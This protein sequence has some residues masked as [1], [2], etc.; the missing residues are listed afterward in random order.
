MKKNVHLA[1]NSETQ[2]SLHYQA[3]WSVSICQPKISV[4][5]IFTMITDSE[6]LYHRSCQS[7]HQIYLLQHLYFLGW[8]M[9]NG[10]LHVIAVRAWPGCKNKQYDHGVPVYLS[11]KLCTIIFTTA[12]IWNVHHSASQQWDT[13]QS[14]AACRPVSVPLL[15]NP[16]H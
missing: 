6:K 10:P 15:V 7:V 14:A 13:D 1:S 11:Y 3:H 2:P 9:R 4:T 5:T 12:E 8:G 16:S